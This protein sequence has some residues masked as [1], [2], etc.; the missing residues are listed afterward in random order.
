ME[1]AFAEYTAAHLAQ[2]QEA[3]KRE[4]D[5]NTSMFSE[6]TDREQQFW[7]VGFDVYIG[8]PVVAAAALE[9]KL[10]GTFPGSDI[11]S[12]NQDQSKADDSDDE[13]DQLHT[14]FANAKKAGAANIEA[15][16]QAE[17]KRRKRK[18]LEKA[19][20]TIMAGVPAPTS[21]LASVAQAQ[22]IKQ[23]KAGG[24]K[25]IE[26]AANGGM[27]AGGVNGVPGAIVPGR[28]PSLPRNQL[29]LGGG[30]QGVA[31]GASVGAIG[32]NAIASASGGKT[33]APGGPALSEDDLTA[34]PEL[35]HPGLR[36]SFEVTEG[37]LLMGILGNVTDPVLMQRLEQAVSEFRSGGKRTGNGHG[38]SN[39]DYLLGAD[40]QPLTLKQY[41]FREFEDDLRDDGDID[42][43]AAMDDSEDENEPDPNDH[44]SN[45]DSISGITGSG[46]VRRG[47]TMVVK[48]ERLAQMAETRKL[49]KIAIS[50]SLERYADDCEYQ[51]RLYNRQGT[52]MFIR[53]SKKSL[54][55][56]AI[57]HKSGPRS[58]SG[59]V[60]RQQ[61]IM[62]DGDTHALTSGGQTSTYASAILEATDCLG[63][64]GIR[65]CPAYQL[66]FATYQLY[67]FKVHSGESEFTKEGRLRKEWTRTIAAVHDADQQ[68]R[69]EWG[70]LETPE[71]TAQRE[72]A[73]VRAKHNE[74]GEERSLEDMKRAADRQKQKLAILDRERRAKD[75]A[76]RKTQQEEKDRKDAADRKEREEQERR[77]VKIDPRTGRPVVKSPAEIEQERRQAEFEMARA[78]LV[79][80]FVQTVQCMYRMASVV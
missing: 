34:P 60:K 2:E 62:V 25:T 65:A 42:M 7:S 80:D 78:G 54:L 68:E 43:Q 66:G 14:D 3:S 21:G 23:L 28:G 67:P 1:K 61:G 9:F 55:A 50:N 6:L 48:A 74:Q 37:Y 69:K 36:I 27:G 72:A 53:L 5:R 22:F 8:D 4:K 56:A 18:E 47:S 77:T 38:P 70:A 31:A 51:F 19:I 11:D 79:T 59:R 64:Q 45:L 73:A 13:E 20:A 29:L 26:A 57:E 32:A 39:K 49:N 17:L 33:S 15:A 30:T 52:D 44:K 16:G 12:N 75:E 76:I 63:F 24:Q 40:G 46:K 35:I 71:Q 58:A 10:N 41:L